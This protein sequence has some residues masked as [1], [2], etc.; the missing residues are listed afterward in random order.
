MGILKFLSD[1]TGFTSWSD[2]Y[3]QGENWANRVIEQIGP[4]TT[5]ELPFEIDQ[6]FASDLAEE[7]SSN[8]NGFYAGFRDTWNEH[9]DEV[10]PRRKILGLF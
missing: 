8:P 5:Y 10:A 4:E 9:V 6:E 3:D 1:V 2:S 7:Y